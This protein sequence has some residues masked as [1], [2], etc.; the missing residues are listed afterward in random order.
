MIDRLV[1]I[2]REGPR[3]FQEINDDPRLMNVTTHAVRVAV[4]LLREFDF[5]KIQTESGETQLKYRLSDS[6][7]KFL[8]TIE[9]IETEEGR[10]RIRDTRTRDV[11]GPRV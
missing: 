8:A 5:I 4:D 7:L 6:V 9:Q 3:T 10:E 11:S 1:A 2:L